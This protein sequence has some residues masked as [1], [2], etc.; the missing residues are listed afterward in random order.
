MSSMRVFGIALLAMP[1]LAQ[2]GLY[3]N[4]S[5]HPAIGQPEAIAAGGKLFG[6]SCA[7]C[8]GPDGGGGARGPNLVHRSRWHPLSTGQVTAAL[9]FLAEVVDSP[10]Q[11]WH[12]LGHVSWAVYLPELRLIV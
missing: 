8:H 5:Q 4:D 9:S 10:R 2:H 3:L 7:G 6:G 1:L 12:R 11:V